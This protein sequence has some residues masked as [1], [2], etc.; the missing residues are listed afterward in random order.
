MS[1]M[2]IYQGVDRTAYVGERYTVKVARSKPRQFLQSAMH[3]KERAGFR[4]IVD[5]WRALTADQH[6]S[7]KNFLFHGVVSNRRESHLSEQYEDVVTPTL[8][9]LGG[10]VNVQHTAAPTSLDHDVIHA[11]FAEHLGPRVTTLGHMLENTG[12]LGV[13]GGHVRF[14]DGGSRGLE[15]LMVSHPDAIRQA[16]GSLTLQ[17]GS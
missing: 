7:L 5:A 15:E 13:V 11:A 8:S 14:V 10:L 12:N 1:P 4:G 17:L 3:T 9:V 16:L 2:E 6:Q